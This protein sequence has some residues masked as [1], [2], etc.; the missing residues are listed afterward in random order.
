MKSW[1]SIF[2]LGRN[3]DNRSNQQSL[4]FFKGKYDKINRLLG[5]T[6]WDLEMAQGDIGELWYRFA[7]KISST[8]KDNIT[9]SKSMTKKNSIRGNTELNN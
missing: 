4:L 6:D 5:T 3:E 9:V 7:D 1:N 8:Y 2:N